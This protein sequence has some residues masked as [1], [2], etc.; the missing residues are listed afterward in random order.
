M[1]A[2]DYRGEGRWLIFVAIIFAIDIVLRD[3]PAVVFLDVLAVM[4]SLSLAVWRGR[5]GSLRRAAISGYIIGGSVAGIFSSA[6]P[7]PV[8]VTDID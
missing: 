7:V 4:I 2:R 1:G 5:G 6:G 3:S 8:S